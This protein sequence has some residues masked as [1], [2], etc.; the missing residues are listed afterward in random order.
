MAPHDEAGWW[1]RAGATL[2]VDYAGDQFAAQRCQSPWDALEGPGSAVTELEVRTDH[3]VRYCAGHEHLSRA[4]QGADARPDV[5]ADSGHVAVSPF[6][7]AGVKT[8][9]HFESERLDGLLRSSPV[10]PSRRN[11]FRRLLR[12]CV[13]VVRLGS[14]SRLATKIA[15]FSYRPS[16]TEAASTGASRSRCRSCWV[17]KDRSGTTEQ[18][19]SKA[20]T[21]PMLGAEKIS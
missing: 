6:D 11:W 2:A 7:F 21:T 3:K 4:R 19:T 20:P 14:D 12:F 15:G 9:A 16:Q 13:P 17:R 5:H 10:V 8:G 18:L 1:F